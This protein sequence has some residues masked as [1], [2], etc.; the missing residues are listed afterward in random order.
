MLSFGSETYQGEFLP[1]LP[2][3]SL[4]VPRLTTRFIGILIRGSM[5]SLN[6]NSSGPGWCIGS[7]KNSLK[8]FPLLPAVTKQDEAKL[9]HTQE[10][11]TPLTLICLTQGTISCCS[12]EN[13]SY[14]KL[15][16]VLWPF[17]RYYFFAVE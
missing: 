9:F 1:L 2:Y 16:I 13:S 5:S 14:V 17:L 6:A 11:E 7:E 15:H 8:F 4:G 3:V 10:G 12:T